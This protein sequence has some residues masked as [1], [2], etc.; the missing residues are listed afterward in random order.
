MLGQINEIAKKR[1]SCS[2]EVAVIHVALGQNDRAFEWFERA[3]E[4]RS[5]CMPNLNVNPRLDP[6]RADPRFLN[7]L[8]SVG[9]RE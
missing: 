8:Q 5:D 6:L 1:Y 3:R 7:L 9:F 4:A 2:Y